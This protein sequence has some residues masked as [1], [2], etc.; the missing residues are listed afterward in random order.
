METFIATTP[1]M[2]PTIVPRD[3]FMVHKTAPLQRWNVIAFHSPES[4]SNIYVSRLVGLPGEQVE[5]IEGK[6]FINGKEAAPPPGVGP[7]VSTI[8]SHLGNGC[9]GN[10]IR[11]A[12]DEY[13]VLGDNTSVAADSRYWMTAPPGHQPGAVPGSYIVGRATW[14]YWPVSR[15]RK[16]EP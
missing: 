14:I 12:S 4:P 15:W 16:L 10:P 7:Y 6:V 11:L 13:Y 9:E 1:P 8:R 3:R 5:L 2:S